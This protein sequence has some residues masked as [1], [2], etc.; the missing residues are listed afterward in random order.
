VRKYIL[1][2]PKDDHGQPIALF[3]LNLENNVSKAIDQLSGI[4]SGI[5]ADGVVS[6]IEAR[7]FCEYV[8]K[9]GVYEPVWPFTDI[10]SRIERIFANGVCCDDEREELKGVMEALCGYCRNPNPS[11]TYSTDLPLDS[12]PPDVVI[13]PERNFVITSRFAFGTRR[14]LIEAIT[15]RLGIASDSFPTLESHYL[16]IGMFASRDWANT[17]YGRKIERAVELRDSGSG[18][19]IIS[20]EH[21]QKFI[22]SQDGDEPKLRIAANGQDLGEFPVITVKEMLKSGRLT[23]Q[24]YYLD[25]GSNEWV[26]LDHRT[27]LG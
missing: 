6:D 4:C 17:N 23:R 24:D 11:E 5:L 8:R 12:P 10:L 7:F 26:P 27:D 3:K 14:K 9:F 1:T 21:W 22:A 18:I 13:F 2:T 25:I 19:C 15:D 20:E 16:V